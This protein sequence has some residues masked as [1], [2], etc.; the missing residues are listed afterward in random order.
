[1]VDILAA[2]KITSKVSDNLGIISLENQTQKTRLHTD[3]THMCAF[4]ENHHHV[5]ETKYPRQGAN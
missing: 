4:G 5:W 1:M 2:W 3:C